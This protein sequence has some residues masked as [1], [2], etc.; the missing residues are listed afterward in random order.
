ML[1]EVLS[2]ADAPGIDAAALQGL[3]A[4]RSLGWPAA[5]VG[6]AFSP[7]GRALAGW[8]QA[9]APGPRVAAAPQTEAVL[10][11]L[12]RVAGA[13]ER[14][15]ATQERITE[16]LERQGERLAILLDRGPR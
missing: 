10:G 11:A 3:I 7:L 1:A 2:A 16:M 8:L 12:E 6:V 14:I 15:A 13:Q 4:L 5:A 9:L